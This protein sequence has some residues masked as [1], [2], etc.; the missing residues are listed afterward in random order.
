MATPETA[1]PPAQQTNGQAAVPTLA[2]DE[3][4]TMTVLQRLNWAQRQVDYVQKTKPAGLRYSI[5]SHDAVTAAVRPILVEAGVLYYPHSMVLKQDGDRTELVFMVRFVSIDMPS[6]HIDVATV[7]YGLDNSDKGPGKAISYGVKYALLKALGLETGDDPDLEQ[8]T[9]H[10][11][12]DLTDIDRNIT[13][14]VKVEDLAG[15]PDAIKNSK[16]LS[17]PQK[18][19]LTQRYTARYREFVPKG[20]A[21]PKQTAPQAAN[22]DDTFPGDR[23]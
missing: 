15:I 14:A 10:T 19:Q 18:Q 21:A 6:D 23:P 22:D 20:S 17:M 8:T 7:G 13:S 1:P 12:N 2:R 3:R 5:V 9:V 4:Q 11:P 16:S